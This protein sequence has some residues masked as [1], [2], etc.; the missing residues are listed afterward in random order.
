MENK[1]KCRTCKICQQQ[2]RQQIINEFEAQNKKYTIQDINQ[3]LYSIPQRVIKRLSLHLYTE[4]NIS[5][6]QYY[7]LYY[8]I[9]QNDTVEMSPKAFEIIIEEMNKNHAID[10]IQHFTK[11][12]AEVDGNAFRLEKRLYGY[13]SQIYQYLNISTQ[14]KSRPTTEKKLLSTSY[15][16]YNPVFKISCKICNYQ[17]DSQYLT[18]HIIK[19]H[20]IDKMQYYIQYLNFPENINIT[21]L[22]MPLALC[23]YQEL[24]AQTEYDNYIDLYSYH[25]QQ[26]KKYINYISNFDYNFY[27]ACQALNLNT[28]YDLYHA[29]IRIGCRTDLNNQLFR[30]SWEANIARILQ[31]ENITYE[32]EKYRFNVNINNKAYYYIPDFYLGNN[33]FIE[34]KGFMR[35]ISCKK[36]QA[37]KKQYPHYILMLIN[38]DIYYYILK[39]YKNRIL[40]LEL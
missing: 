6:Q 15:K 8:N 14:G 27:Q 13:H 9:P 36:I 30:S 34:V 37:F 5:L 19:K 10:C 28:V 11:I 23:M 24:Q 18:Q 38:E 32:Y 4:H 40:T 7:E 1:W 29:H 25:I 3:Q 22:P 39:Q 17:T 12:L 16:K 35:E 20:G 33:I 31:Y 21:C 26:Y 2:Q